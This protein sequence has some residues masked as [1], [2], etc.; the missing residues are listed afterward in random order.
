MGCSGGVEKLVLI[1]DIGGFFYEAESEVKQVG[2]AAS[3]RSE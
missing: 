1:E 2:R 3:L